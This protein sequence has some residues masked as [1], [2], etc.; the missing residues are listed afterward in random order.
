MLEWK[1]TGHPKKSS[2]SSQGTSIQGLLAERGKSPWKNPEMTGCLFGDPPCTGS[3]CLSVPRTYSCLHQPAMN[4][5]FLPCCWG[6][7]GVVVGLLPCALCGNVV[8]GLG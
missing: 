7:G 2:G 3:L 8:S 4:L 5:A 6:Y 1:P